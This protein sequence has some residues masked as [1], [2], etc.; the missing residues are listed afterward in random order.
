MEITIIVEEGLVQEVYAE[1][2]NVI[3]NVVDLDVQGDEEELRE[4]E[5]EAEEARSQMYSVWW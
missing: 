4:R 2:P 1:D 5:E 3:V